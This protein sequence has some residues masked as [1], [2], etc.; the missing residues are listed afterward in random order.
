MADVVV[1]HIKTEMA[2]APFHF[3][4]DE[5]ISLWRMETKYCKGESV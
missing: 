2:L 3:I 4:G 1:L 5:V